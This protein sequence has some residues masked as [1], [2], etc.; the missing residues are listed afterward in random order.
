MKDFV[1]AHRSPA[2]PRPKVTAPARAVAPEA[3]PA[4]MADFGEPDAPADAPADERGPPRDWSK[5]FD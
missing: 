4:W 1:E 3:P 2:R 5:D